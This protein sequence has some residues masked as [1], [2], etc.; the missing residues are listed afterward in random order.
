MASQRAHYVS[1]SR[2]LELR[3]ACIW[4]EYSAGAGFAILT[5]LTLLPELMT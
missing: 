1:D 5:A 4:G 3:Q 2:T